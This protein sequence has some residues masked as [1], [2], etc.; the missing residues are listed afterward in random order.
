[1]RWAVILAALLSAPAGAQ[2]EAPPT[3]APVTIISRIAAQ[4]EVTFDDPMLGIA[5]ARVVLRDMPPEK[6]IELWN[7]EYPKANAEQKAK[8]RDMVNAC[9]G[10]PA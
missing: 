7:V 10:D 1:M 8:V 3:I 2:E 6:Y 4:C 9:M 5:W